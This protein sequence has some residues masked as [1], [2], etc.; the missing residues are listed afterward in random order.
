MVQKL[1]RPVS[2]V[3]HRFDPLPQILKNVRF[4]SGRPLDDSA[5]QRAIQDGERRLGNAG[6]LLIRPSG[7]EPLIRVMAEGED[8]DL[9]AAVVDEICQV[10]LDAAANTEDNRPRIARLG[11]A[12]AAE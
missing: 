1:R 10:I 2:E 11:S 3:C 8:D 4:S 6:R 7:T 9:V 5:V 12:Q